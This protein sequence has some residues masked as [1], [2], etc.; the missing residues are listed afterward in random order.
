MAFKVQRGKTQDYLENLYHLYLVK[1]R[2]S[3]M[4]RE[5]I[6]NIDDEKIERKIN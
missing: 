5:G 1:S 2:R 4:L 6:P 3:S